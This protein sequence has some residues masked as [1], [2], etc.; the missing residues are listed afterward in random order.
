MAAHLQKYLVYIA[1]TGQVPLAADNFDDDWEPIG[2]MVR[3]DLVAAGM[4]VYLEGGIVA[5]TPPT[6]CVA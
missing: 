1:N 2:P 6:T 5:V 4:I 3:R